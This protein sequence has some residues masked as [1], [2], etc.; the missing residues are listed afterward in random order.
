MSN[1]NKILDNKTSLITGCNKGIGKS[2]VKTF[3]AAGSNI[4]ACMRKENE[5]FLNFKKDL[6]NQFKVKIDT[7][8]F[9]LVDEIQIKNFYDKV[10]TN[11]EKIDILVNNAGTIQNSLFQ[12]TPLKKLNETFKINFFN[13][14][15]L[16][17]LIVKK[18]QKNKKGSIINVSSTSA[19]EG[20]IGR[21]S[22]ASSKSSLI[23]A[24]K[25]MSREL[26]QFGIRVNSIC[27]GL[28]NTD[29]MI[30]NTDKKILSEITERLNLKRI[31][32]PDEIANVIA[33]LASDLSS[34]L[35][36]ENIIVDGGL[37]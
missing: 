28:T 29:M 26:G 5:E 30:N 37:T 9:D 24:S 13:Q 20:N 4:I 21:L 15:Y 34:Y 35:T 23:T 10:N 27:P 19:I 7:Y 2:T 14:I 18:M 8:Y 6:E 11:Y 36:G 17:Q 32:E 31:A 22:Y 3:A 33:F 1:Y 12:M 16:S 25:V